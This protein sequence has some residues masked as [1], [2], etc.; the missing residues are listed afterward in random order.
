M[1]FCPECGTKVEG[2][3]FCP[4]CGYK[5]AV[6]ESSQIQPQKQETNVTE[7]EEKVILEFS[8]FMFGIDEKMKEK[9]IDKIPNKENYTLTTE[10]LLIEKQGVI[11]SKREEIELYT[12]KDINVKQSMKDKIMKVGDIEIISA[13][14]STPNILLKRIK[15]PYE[16]K[17]QIR[18]A[19]INAKK[20]MGVQFRTNI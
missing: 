18:R 3:K 15:E 1:K 2:M 6:A 7:Q 10:R 11:G 5:V 14:E 12:V 20:N 9:G 13:D 19:V 8:T 16:V 4:E 17:E